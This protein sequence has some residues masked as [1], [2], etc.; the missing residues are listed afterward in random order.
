MGHALSQS[1][2]GEIVGT[3]GLAYAV[4][5]KDKLPAGVTAAGMVACKD[6]S[7]YD[8]GLVIAL[9][10]EGSMD[11][12]TALGESGAAAHTPVVT[13][14]S[15]RLPRMEEWEQM[16]A[17]RRDEY[18]YYS[19]TYTDLN[20]AIGN[21]GGTPLVKPS[22]GHWYFWSSDEY[23]DEEARCMFLESGFF[24]PMEMDKIFTDDFQVRACFEFDF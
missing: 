1:E 24:T 22:E 9:A 16:F 7:E 14:Y 20:T 18:D 23:N 8:K 17:A 19:D 2:F 13:G 3:D 10:N 6:E 5:Y 12:Y 11:W 4:A 15:W 21:A